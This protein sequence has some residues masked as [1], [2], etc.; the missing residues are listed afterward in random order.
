M[1]EDNLKVK[2]LQLGERKNPTGLNTNFM[3]F[4]SYPVFVLQAFPL[5]RYEFG[6]LTIHNEVSSVLCLRHKKRLY[7]TTADK[8]K[9][10]FVFK[11]R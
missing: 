10:E 1:S 6:E 7:D 9:R 11:E 5:R 8:R 2:N 4:I 3:E